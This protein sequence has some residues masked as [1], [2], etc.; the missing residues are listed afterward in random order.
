M[1]PTFERKFLIA[2][3]SVLLVACGGG[4]GESTSSN[5]PDNLQPQP[6]TPPIN[7]IVERGCA[8]KNVPN[9]WSGNDY[10][11]SIGDYTVS[12]N[13]QNKQNLV[14]WTVCIS[15]ASLTEKGIKAEFDIDWPSGGSV[16]RS[17]TNVS[18]TPNIG[19]SNPHSWMGT[20]ALDPISITQIGDTRISHDLV[21]DYSG[22]T[23]T[24]LRFAL[25]PSSTKFM[26]R[27]PLV[28]MGINL[29]PLPAGP[30]NVV[31][32][33]NVDG[34]TFWVEQ[35]DSIVDGQKL[36]GLAFHGQQNFFKGTVRLKAFFDYILDKKIFP[37]TYYLHSIELGMEA[38]QGKGKL[39]INEFNVKK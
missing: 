21:V 28:E 29:H 4:T 11:R 23:Q 8:T 39:I 10:T 13:T 25:D 17:F 15:S 1:K 12:T 18:Y 22:Y 36:I 33:I 34:N 27:A 24:F 6:T 19:F 2:A 20:K 30:R 32:T 9:P 14:D 31:D 37:T 5:T 7:T 38:T 3:T 16:I 35:T 26:D